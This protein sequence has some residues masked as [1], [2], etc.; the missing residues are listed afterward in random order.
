[1]TASILRAISRR[2]LAALVFA[3]ALSGLA[4]P[5]AAAQAQD[6]TVR[7]V[8]DYGD[9]ALKTFT[10]LPWSKGTTVLD[11]MNAAKSHSRGIDF[12]YQGSGSTAFL[13]EIDKLAGQG[14]GQGKKNWQ[15]WV[16]TAYADRS[17][18]IY[19]LQALDVVTWRFATGP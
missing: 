2:A 3:A 1:M 10:G 15:Y 16:N 9:G 6:M 14:G 7:L 4:A 17:F 18:G 8:I 5:P 13:T 19:E 11:V 12:V